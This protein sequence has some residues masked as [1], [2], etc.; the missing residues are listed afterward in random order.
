[1]GR[2]STGQGHGRL[3]EGGEVEFRREGARPRTDKS[4]QDRGPPV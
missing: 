4:G 3:R 1:M 2:L